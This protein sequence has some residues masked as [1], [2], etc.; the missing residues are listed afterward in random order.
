M[1]IDVNIMNGRLSSQKI[2]VTGSAK[3][4]NKIKNMIKN[5]DVFDIAGTDIKLKNNETA[6]SFLRKFS[7]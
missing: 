5:G 4:I 7:G 2:T 3:N 6:S 1:K